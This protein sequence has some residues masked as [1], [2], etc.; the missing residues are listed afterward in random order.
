MSRETRELPGIVSPAPAP[1]PLFAPEN[2][3]TTAQ[4]AFIIFFRYEIQI[5]IV[6][7]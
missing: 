2:D 7:Y 3:L 5:L 4:S 1:I 6:S